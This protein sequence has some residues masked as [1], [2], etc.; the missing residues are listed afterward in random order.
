M[1]VTILIADKGRDK[2]MLGDTT[3]REQ[4]EGLR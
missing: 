2:P 1:C 4:I 3:L